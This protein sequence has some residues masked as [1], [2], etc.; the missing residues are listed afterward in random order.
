M[1]R[2][3]VVLCGC[4]QRNRLRRFHAG[5]FLYNCLD[6][7]APVA[8]VEPLAHADIL[9][10]VVRVAKWAVSLVALAGM[11]HVLTQPAMSPGLPIGTVAARANTT[12]APRD[13]S[14]VVRRRMDNSATVSFEADAG[15]SYAVRLVD[16]ETQ[17]EEMLLYVAAGESIDTPLRP[18]RYRITAAAGTGWINDDE[19]FGP[20]THFYRFEARGADG[21]LSLSVGDSR[22]IRLKTSLASTLQRSPIQRDEF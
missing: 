21:G 8:Q 11:M 12:I 3:V 9:A 4:G 6:C 18:G 14:G 15:S 19:L 20:A 1:S 13:N 16:I 2:E 22:V 7:G 5:P 10:P 17:R